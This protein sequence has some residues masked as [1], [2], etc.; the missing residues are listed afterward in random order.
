MEN[1]TGSGRADALVGS[2]MCQTPDTG[3][4]QKYHW[5]TYFSNTAD[6]L[7]LAFAIVELSHARRSSPVGTS[8]ASTGMP[9]MSWLVFGFDSFSC[10]SSCLC[11]CWLKTS[12]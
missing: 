3:L 2:V 7:T 5:E 11:C 8:A 10:M 4:M 1:E 6:S 12:H 9:S